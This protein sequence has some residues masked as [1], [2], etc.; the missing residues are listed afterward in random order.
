MA[1][2]CSQESMAAAMAAFER[3]FGTFEGIVE[4]D[5][6]ARDAR[7]AKEQEAEEAAAMAASEAEFGTF[8]A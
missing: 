3:E 5:R 8:G 7:S 6:K 1:C 2:T 4:E